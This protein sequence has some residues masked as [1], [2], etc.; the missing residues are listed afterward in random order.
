VTT[1][2]EVL[3]TASDPVNGTGFTLDLNDTNN[4]AWVD[5]AGGDEAADL[6]VDPFGLNQD[7]A[8]SGAFSVQRIWSNAQAAAG[9]DPCVPVPAGEVYFNV[10]PSQAFFV[11][12]VG[13]SVT[14]EVTAF[15]DGP[16]DAWTLVAQDWSDDPPMQFL[17]ISFGGVS[18]APSTQVKAG[19]TVSVTA[20]LIADPSGLPTQEADGAL[21]SVEGTLANPV[22]ARYWPFA[23]TTHAIAEDYG[24]MQASRGRRHRPLR[25]TLPP[26]AMPLP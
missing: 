16:T 25:R 13:Q 19:Q 6:C 2:H 26:A 3:E 17:D 24:I 5:I 22:V 1:S 21:I 18:G 8:S 20:K 12:N 14:F 15:A 7:V 10:A 4:W 9:H 23:V 11:T